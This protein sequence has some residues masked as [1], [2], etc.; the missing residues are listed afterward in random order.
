[1]F[2]KKFLFRDWV[3]W[4]PCNLPKNRSEI[5]MNVLRRESSNGGAFFVISFV[6][7]SNTRIPG[8]NPGAFLGRGGS[9]CRDSFYR[10]AAMIAAEIAFFSFRTGMIS[11]RRP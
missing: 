3:F 2:G 6:P 5:R 9:A 7:D 8:I 11:E 10:R 1:M 4:F